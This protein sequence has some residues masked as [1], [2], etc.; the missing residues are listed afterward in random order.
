MQERPNAEV[1]FQYGTNEGKLSSEEVTHVKQTIDAS[2]EL[3]AKKP[4]SKVDTIPFTVDSSLK[5]PFSVFAPQAEDYSEMMQSSVYSLSFEAS[6]TL[7]PNVAFQH[8]TSVILDQLVSKPGKQ[9]DDSQPLK[10]R[11]IGKDTVTETQLNTGNKFDKLIA[12]CKKEYTLTFNPK[13]AEYN[14]KQMIRDTKYIR[15]IPDGESLR[16][17]LNEAKILG[18]VHQDQRDKY[19]IFSPTA[20]AQEVAALFSRAL[21]VDEGYN[22]ARKIYDDERRKGGLTAD[23]CI[24]FALFQ[25][26]WG[27]ESYYMCLVAVSSLGKDKFNNSRLWNALVKV[28]SNLNATTLARKPLNEGI[29][30][31]TLFEV[32]DIPPPRLNNVISTVTYK[33]EDPQKY[34]P[35]ARC[36]EKHYLAEMFKLFRT[37][38]KKARLEGVVNCNFKAFRR[39]EGEFIENVLNIDN[40]EYFD[41]KPLCPN[42]VINRLAYIALCKQAI[43]SKSA[44]NLPSPFRSNDGTK[45]SILAL[46]AHEICSGK[47]IAHETR[48]ERKIEQPAKP[49]ISDGK[50]EVVDE[51]SVTVGNRGTYHSSRRR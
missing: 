16:K 7:E 20:K 19:N 43:E 39:E 32:L 51:E 31:E 14:Y 12:L 2:K 18:A 28:A 9:E 33:F 21:L 27:D 22:K 46:L 8:S 13:D 4:S 29:G 48:R 17:F 36:S 47:E 37:L 44:E 26:K 6:T 30:K 38:G 5:N 1:E 41:L 25:L 10:K 40:E 3:R 11:R 15:E 42:C 49:V 34:N 24:S 45:P 50:L 23:P 35:D